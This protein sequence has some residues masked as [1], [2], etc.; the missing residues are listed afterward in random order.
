MGEVKETSCFQRLGN[1]G[2]VFRENRLVLRGPAGVD[3]VKL[4]VQGVLPENEVFDGIVRAKP[5]QGLEIPGVVFNLQSQADIDVVFVF[6]LQVQ[7]L[8][9]IALQLLRKHPEGGTVAS[10]KGVRRMVRKTEDFVSALDGPFHVFSLGA[11]GVIA[12]CGVAVVI[13]KHPVSSPFHVPPQEGMQG[14]CTTDRCV[15]QFAG[16]VFLFRPQG[17]KPRRRIRRDAECFP[18]AVLPLLMHNGYAPGEGF[19]RPRK[20]LLAFTGAQTS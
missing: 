15:K 10:V 8:P 9:D 16:R 19:T 14:D 4:V 11:D 1:L 5:E 13:G 20:V 6:R 17:S 18:V 7:G 2:A 3:P 12:A